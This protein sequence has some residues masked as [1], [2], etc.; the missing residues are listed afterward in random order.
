M[1]M[2]TQLR[3]GE[4]HYDELA[5]LYQ[6]AALSASGSDRRVLVAEVL[7]IVGDLLHADNVLLFTLDE[8][9]K[10]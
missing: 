3:E 1:R 8:D 2:G 9:E 10:Q 7:R 6:I 5:A 4:R